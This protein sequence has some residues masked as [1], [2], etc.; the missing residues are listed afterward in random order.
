MIL[1]KDSSKGFLWIKDKDS[2]LS[3]FLLQ[4]IEMKESQIK[5]LFKSNP[6]FGYKSYLISL[7]FFF[8]K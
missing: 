4:S 7:T 3:A 6:I 8:L 5:R 2:V 1:G